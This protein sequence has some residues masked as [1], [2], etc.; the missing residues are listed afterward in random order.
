MIGVVCFVVTVAT[1]A[2]AARIYTRAV[3]IRSMGPDD[4]MAIFSLVS[5]P[6]F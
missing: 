5:L 2:V 6:S 4:Y 3:I 1:L